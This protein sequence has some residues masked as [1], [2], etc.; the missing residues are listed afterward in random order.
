MDFLNE[1]FGSEMGELKR[2]QKV[3]AACQPCGDQHSFCYQ[4]HSLLFPN[5]ANP[6]MHVYR[7]RRRSR[8]FARVRSSPS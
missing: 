8:S 4:P 2:H 6:E 3:S 7:V 1:L 5:V